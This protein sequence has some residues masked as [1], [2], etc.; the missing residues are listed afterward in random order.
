MSFQCIVCIFRDEH[1]ASVGLKGSILCV[2]YWTWYRLRGHPPDVL[3]PNKHKPYF[4]ERLDLV[5]AHGTRMGLSGCEQTAHYASVTRVDV[6]KNI[7]YNYLGCCAGFIRWTRSQLSILKHIDGN[8]FL[9]LSMNPVKRPEPT[10]C[11]SVSR[12]SLHFDFSISF[13]GLVSCLQ[14]GTVCRG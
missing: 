4:S 13:I 3:S 9:L 5:F 6:T 11:L 8:L 14:K 1:N 2:H 10:M 7:L 12:K